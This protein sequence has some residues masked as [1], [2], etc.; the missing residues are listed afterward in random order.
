MV[1]SVILI[2]PVSFHSGLALH[3][4]HAQSGWLSYIVLRQVQ[5]S[6]SG[7]CYW[8]SQRL[9]MLHLKVYQ[10]LLPLFPLLWV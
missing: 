2:T 6:H 9:A 3:N 7:L 8:L 5:Q 1:P 10:I 4:V